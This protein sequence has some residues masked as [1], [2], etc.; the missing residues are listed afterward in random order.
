MINTQRLV[1]V[2]GVPE[3]AQVLRAVFEPRGHRV[4]RIRAYELD[5]FAQDPRNLLVLHQEDTPPAPAP[6]QLPTTPRVIIGSLSAEDARDSPTSSPRLQQPFHY[7]ELIRAV[8][9][10]LHANPTRKAA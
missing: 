3:T 4:D 7:A 6:P 8:E 5:Q 9:S 1:V 10:L 2:D